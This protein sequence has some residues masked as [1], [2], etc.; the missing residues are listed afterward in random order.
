[1][2]LQNNTENL[3]KNYKI[4]P[5]GDY[6]ANI[7]FLGTGTSTGVPQLGCGCNTCRST[8]SRDK[9]LRC[10]A[11]VTIN[12]K[13]ILIDAG[14][15]LRQQLITN[16]IFHI[17]G[18]LLTHEHYDHVGGLDDVRPLGEVKIYAERKVL[19]AIQRNMPYCF[20]K[21]KNPGVPS[22]DL[23]E[24]NGSEFEIEGIRITPIRIMHARL[25]ILGF[26]IGDIAYLTDVKTIDETEIHKLQGVKILVVNALREEPHHSHFNLQ[27]AL[28]FIALIQ[29]E[30]AYLT[31]ISHLF[32]FHE[33][34][35][36]K[37]PKNVYLAYDNL[38]ITI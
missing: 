8:D 32:G 1:M 13:R 17:D 33:D 20:G 4:L 10:S 38:E 28:D 15:D 25:P 36:K 21:Y 35:Q 9:R 14:P 27:E 5:S 34:I 6:G 24:I 37:L 11:L 23:Y 29:P 7:L 22:L 3:S 18:I 31:H 19:D 16:K 2:N 30:K 12:G 26:R